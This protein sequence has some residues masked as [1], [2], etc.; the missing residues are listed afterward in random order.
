MSFN[1]RHHLFFPTH[2]A[3]RYPYVTSFDKVTLYQY[4]KGYGNEKIREEHKVIAPYDIGDQDDEDTDYYAE[5]ISTDLRFL[6]QEFD[7]TFEDISIEL[8]NL[9][10]EPLKKIYLQ[11]VIYER[12]RLLYTH[13]DTILF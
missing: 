13:D 2:Y 4:C 12:T 7:I 11:R 8:T 1:T 9:F 10:D 5:D 6:F 3:H